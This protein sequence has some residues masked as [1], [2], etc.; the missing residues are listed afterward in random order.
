MLRL[1]DPASFAAT[2][3]GIDK[4]ATVDLTKF[5]AVGSSYANG[6]LTLSNASQATVSLKIPGPFTA[7]EF[8]LAD[9]TTGGT[10]ITWTP[11]GQTFT[12]TDGSDN[13]NTPTAW[14][15]A[16]VPT[17]I[18]SAV[19]GD[20]ASNTITVSDAEAI[21]NL[22]LNG[23]NDTLEITITGNLQAGPIAINSGTLAVRDGGSLAAS[24]IADHGLLDL[25]GNHELI[26]TPLSLG[27]TLQVSPSAFNAGGNSHARTRR[28]PYPGPRQRSDHRHRQ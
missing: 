12:W 26:N 8:Q 4:G 14:S 5:Q 1:D 25:G 18:D 21:N 24:Q 27:G 16:S 6:V 15:L 2:I 23:T 7:D 3:T 11:V 19:I 13:W 10:N 9:D 20:A 22:T 28:G 17:S